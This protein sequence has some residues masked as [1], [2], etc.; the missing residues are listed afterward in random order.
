M[1]R[2]IALLLAALL[3]CSAAC[4]LAADYPIE[5]KFYRQMLESA[6]RGEI[7]LEAEG[8]DTA[9][10][11]AGVWNLLR[12]LAPR[13]SITADHSY[14][15]GE[16]QAT[17]KLLL[18]GRP[19]GETSLLYNDTLMGLSSDLLAGKNTWYTADKNWNMGQMAQLLFQGD[20]A[21]P[22]LWRT[23]LAVEGAGEEWKTRAREFLTPYETKLSVWVN[24]YAAYASGVQDNV[25]YTELNCQIPANAVKAEIKQL[26]VDFYSDEELLS[27]LREVFTASE[28]A[29]YLQSGMQNTFFIMLDALKMEGE[30]EIIRRYDAAGNLL[31][32]RISLPF[33]KEQ[34]LSRLVLAIYPQ[35]GGQCWD[36]SAWLRSGESY[37]ITCVLGEENIAVGSLKME[38]PPEEKDGDDFI[39]GDGTEENRIIAYDYNLSWDFGEESYTLATDK[40]ERALSATLVIKPVSDTTRPAQALSMEALFSSGSSQRSATSLTGKL[41]WQDL[42]HE[43]SLSLALSGKTAAPFAVDSLDQVTGGLRVDQLEGDALSALLSSWEAGFAEW[44]EQFAAG[45][46][47]AAQ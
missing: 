44:L 18:D 17:L 33:A 27:L 15:R 4:A 40:F 42:D 20:S 29:A 30:V 8:S 23:L 32:D 43:A 36:I 35:E 37:Q 41:T 24:G 39:V 11:D 34:A 10:M 3:C 1:K 19:A 2:L 26:M 22:P 13:L 7:T 21:W 25:M 28:A 45:L 14:Y 9:A 5:E 38:L 6:F 47:P 31:L 46:L 16:G 12:L